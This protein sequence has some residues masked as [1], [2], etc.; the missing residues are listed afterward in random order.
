[1]R[2]QAEKEQASELHSDASAVV[3]LPPTG[4]SPNAPLSHQS[5][6]TVGFISRSAA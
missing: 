3:W 2:S 4:L 1:M 6:L 5:L